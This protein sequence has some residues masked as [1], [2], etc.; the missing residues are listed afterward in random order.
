MMT[1][2]EKLDQI[3]KVAWSN[4]ETTQILRELAAIR[5]ILEGLMQPLVVVKRKPKKVAARL[6]LA[7]YET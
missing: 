6:P 5:E 3:L 1:A 2:E 7:G 4:A